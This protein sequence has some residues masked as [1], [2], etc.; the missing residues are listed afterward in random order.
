MSYIRDFSSISYAIVLVNLFGMELKENVLL[1]AQIRLITHTINRC[2][3]R[4]GFYLSATN[5]ACFYSYATVLVAR[6]SQVCT[7]QSKYT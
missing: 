3:F 4:A 2:I 6:S 1:I 7:R 5:L